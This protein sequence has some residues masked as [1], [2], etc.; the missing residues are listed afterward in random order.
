MTTAVAIRERQ[1]EVVRD[2]LLD[3][4]VDELEV[5]DPEDV[6]L[7]QVAARA[8][9]SIRTLYRYFPTRE[10][11]FK[12][13]GPRIVERVGL[14]TSIDGAADVAPSFLRASGAL[15]RHPRLARSLLLSSLGRMARG[16]QRRG[17]V[18]DVME[19]VGE[20]TDNLDPAEARRRA[21]VIAYL[22]SAAAYLTV[23]DEAELE[24]DDA[25]AAVAWA[26]ETLIDVT[27]REQ[28]PAGSQRRK[29]SK[30][31]T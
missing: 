12:A 18:R 7:P 20:I 24:V 11:L 26:I 28:T 29:H 16:D 21:A 27:R 25:R 3:A 23:S 10:A 9:V 15:S 5:Q 22:C 2:V 17:R 30:E 4:L 31:R 13:V 6:S 19:A 8:E 14:P 1:A